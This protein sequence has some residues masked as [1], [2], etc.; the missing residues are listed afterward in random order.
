MSSSP[1]ESRPAQALSVSVTDDALTID[2][3]DGRSLSVPLDWYPRLAAGSTQERANW[4]L[5]G[6]GEGIH[7]PELDEDVSV[8]GLLAGRGSV[9]AQTSLQRWLRDRKQTG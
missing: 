8:E 7:W 6:R 1:A 3:V 9:E 5:V 4:R 2:L